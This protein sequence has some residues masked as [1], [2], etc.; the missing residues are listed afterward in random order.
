MKQYLDMLRYIRKKGAWK[1]NR[2]G[3]DTL[4]V[5]G[6]TFSHDM[7]T[8]FPLLTTKPMPKKSMAAELECFI[9][10]VTSKK[11]FQDKGCKF[12]DQWCNPQLLKTDDMMTAEQKKQIQIETDDLGPIYGYQWRNFNGEYR[13]GDTVADC[14]EGY[15][16]YDPARDQLLS[17]VNTLKTNPLDRR[18]VVSAW[19]PLQLDQMAL[20]SCHVMWNLV[21]IDGVLHL[22]WFQRSC[23]MLLG[24]PV[25]IASYGLL[26]TLLAKFNGLIA[27]CLKG[28]LCDA[29]IYKDQMEAV[30]IQVKRVPKALPT[31]EVCDADNIF[32]WNFEDVDFNDYNHHD[33][34][35]KVEVAV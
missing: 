35:P 32:K 26:L 6:I 1:G 16:T 10:G 12:W 30:S 22:N 31:V 19:N 2:T 34:L 11:T 27:G 15:P 13:S 28:H 3:I 5:S 29:H 8:G 25:N 14:I 4:S 18:M 33:P 7:R 23:D 17:V 21:C 24:V 9:R 20:P